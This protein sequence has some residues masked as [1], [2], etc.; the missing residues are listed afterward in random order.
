M[1]EPSVMRTVQEFLDGL[2][3]LRLMYE[4]GGRYLALPLPDRR[5]TPS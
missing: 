4:E 1:R 2:V 5:L 3:A